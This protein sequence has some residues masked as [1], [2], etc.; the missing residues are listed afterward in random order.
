MADQTL[1]TVTG[2]VV[3]SSG[4][5]VAGV[6]VH[7]MS[8]G[9]EPG[10]VNRVHSG[11][12]GRFTMHL[13][14]GQDVDLYVYR[15][16]DRTGGPFALA[17]TQDDAG[18]LALPA[19][20][21]VRVLA[22]TELGGG[23]IPA[24]IQI[25]PGPANA[26]PLPTPD[27]RFGEDGVAAGRVQQ[28][29][30]LPGEDQ[31]LR[32]PAGQ[33]EVIVSR[34][35]E[36][37]VHTALVDITDQNCDPAAD[38]SACPTVTPVL[39]RSVATPGMMCGD[40]HIHTRRSNDSGDDPRTKLVSAAADGVEI[41]VRSDHEYVEGWD[42]DVFDLGLESYLYGLASVEL[43]TFQQYG[44][45]GV[46][47][48]DPDPDAPNGGTIP[49]Q[50]YP[51]PEDP[52]VPVATDTPPVVFE[53]VLARPE[54]PALIVNHPSGSKNYF[55]YVGLDSTTGLPAHEDR[56]STSFHAIEV[57]NGNN[58]VACRD[59]Q[60]ADWLSLLDHGLRRAAVGSSDT[61][62]ISREPVGYPRTCLDLGADVPPADPSARRAFADQV[63]DTIIAGDM[64]VSGGIYVTTRVGEF[65]PGDDAT[66]LGDTAQVEITVQAPTWVDVDAIEIV[67]DGQ[68]LEVIPAA[69]FVPGTG[70]VR[71]TATHSVPVGAEGGYVVVAAYGDEPL[72]IHPGYVPFGVANPIYLAR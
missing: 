2:R 4:A 30:A 53:R 10:H 12:D 33:W 8:T 71:H 1:R 19:G 59:D 68:T 3:D 61:H 17:A 18:D 52:D 39:E 14:E 22:A 51:T 7:A 37:E 41:P 69:D 11:D 32:L 35:Y 55:N 66:G 31:V 50:T 23:P 9:A 29:Y 62:G 54:R 25:R 44:H 40:L 5:P 63:R 56:W 65:G 57:F 43:T 72:L 28:V 38:A 27:A 67:V 21:Y 47:P 46:I 34:G 16:G 6:S 42:S 64:I 24:R 58:W 49:W 13:P 48:L 26:D 70:A 36:Y 15:R 60:V 20:G 45:F